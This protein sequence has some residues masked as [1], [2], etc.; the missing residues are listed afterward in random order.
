[1]HRV[2][3]VSRRP[4]SGLPETRDELTF[5]MVRL[6][7]VDFAVGGEKFGQS[8][9]LKIYRRTVYGQIDSGTRG[10]CSRGSPDP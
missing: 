9:S 8:Y 1:M 7:V 3:G 2:L 5:R 10:G 6:G 4:A